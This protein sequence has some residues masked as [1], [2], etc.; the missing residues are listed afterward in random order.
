MLQMQA[1]AVMANAPGFAPGRIA[2]SGSDGADCFRPCRRMGSQP[3][4]CRPEPL[5][6]IHKNIKPGEAMNVVPP[7]LVQTLFL[8]PFIKKSHH[9]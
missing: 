5:K 8:F 2:L 3:L 9:E 4:Q 6:N 1:D 7:G